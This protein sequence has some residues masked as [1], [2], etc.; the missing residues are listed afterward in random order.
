MITAQ[1][2]EY[3]AAK[4]WEEVRF[5]PGMNVLSGHWVLVEKP[6]RKKARW[7]IHGNKQ[8]KGQDYND[9][10]TAA[11][12][13]GSI[14]LLLAITAIED[15]ET[16][17]LDVINAFLNAGLAEEVYMTL[18]HGY[19]KKGIVCRVLKAMFSL[20]QS[21]R[22]WWQDISKKLKELGFKQCLGDHSVYVNKEGVIILLYVDN[23][24]LFAQSKRAIAQAKIQLLNAYKMRN[25][26]DL[27]TFTGIQVLKLPGQ[28]VFI[29]QEDYT[30]TILKKYRFLSDKAIRVPFNDKVVLK[31]RDPLDLY[32]AATIK[33]YQEWIRSFR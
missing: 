15:L 13:S 23:L 10:Y 4:T 16:G 28:R 22:E 20:Y 17:Q 19:G 24:A 12:R 30:M 14:R 1:V 29:Y 2:E 27:K 7:V 11:A 31:P 18:P 9:I 33:Q 8:L 3:V 5:H 6:E 25:I 21:P 26:G 32:S